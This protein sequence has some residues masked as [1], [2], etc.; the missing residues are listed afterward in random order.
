[1]RAYDGLTGGLTPVSVSTKD[2]A[3][4]VNVAAFVDLAACELL[5]RNVAERSEHHTRQRARHRLGEFEPANLCEA[6]IENLDRWRV[7]AWLCQKDVLGLQVATD[8]AGTMRSVN[9]GEDSL[10]PGRGDVRPDRPVIGQS[11]TKSH[12]AKAFHHEVRAS[13]RE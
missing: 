2:D 3:E 12:A 1:M 4:R 9:A 10:E 7:A 13:T 11:R 6:E 8:H 5:W